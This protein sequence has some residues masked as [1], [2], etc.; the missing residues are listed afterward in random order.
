MDFKFMLYPI[1]STKVVWNG[2]YQEAIASYKEALRF[3]NYFAAHQG[4]GNAYA[5]LRLGEE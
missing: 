4:L 2:R 1:K 3:D 5:T